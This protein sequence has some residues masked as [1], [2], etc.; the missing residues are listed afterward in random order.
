MVGQS[1]RLT[2]LA[3]MAMSIAKI[4]CVSPEGWI[5]AVDVRKPTWAV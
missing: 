2:V 1:S 4:D 3:L 5:P